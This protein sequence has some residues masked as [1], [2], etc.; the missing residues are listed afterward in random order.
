MVLGKRFEN[1]VAQEI[2][3]AVADMGQRKQPFRDDG[4]DAG[5]SHALLVGILL[6]EFVDAGVGAAQGGG[7]G[8]FGGR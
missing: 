1:P 2:G 5:R 7:E 6:R 3:A 8:V 4:G